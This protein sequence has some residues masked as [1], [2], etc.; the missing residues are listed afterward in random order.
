[1]KTDKRIEKLRDALQQITR[2]DYLNDAKRLAE[3]ALALDDAILDR[4]RG[5]VDAYSEWEDE[6]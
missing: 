4:D 5:A 6:K 3:K 2:A 1:M